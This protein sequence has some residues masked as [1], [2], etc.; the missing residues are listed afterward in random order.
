MKT[1]LIALLLMLAGCGWHPHHRRYVSSFD[2][3]SYVREHQRPLPQN[4]N[5]VARPDYGG[6]YDISPASGA[7]QSYRATPDAFGN[8]QIQPRG[9]AN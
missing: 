2:G 3:Y 8:Y 9:Y 1:V 6:G 5:Y 7:G 4:R